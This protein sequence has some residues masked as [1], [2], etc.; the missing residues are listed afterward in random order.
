MKF[1]IADEIPW[2]ALTSLSV[3]KLDCLTN[4]DKLPSNLQHLTNLKELHIWRC[5]MTV[6]PEW[7]KDLQSL[8][9][10]AIWVCPYMKSLPEGIRSLTS[11]KNLEIE[12][13]PTL[14]QR[15]QKES[16]LNFSLH[17]GIGQH[18]ESRIYFK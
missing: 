11:L 14:L 17:F 1:N 8:E 18:A 6:L 9:K 2:E 16:E 12:D 7:I 10:L 13:C 3:L 5:K 4:L 15:C